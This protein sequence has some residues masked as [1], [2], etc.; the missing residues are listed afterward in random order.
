[1]CSGQSRWNDIITQ[2]L[3]KA[4]LLTVWRQPAGN[5]MEWR[6][7]GAR[8]VK[9][10]NEESGEKEQSKKDERKKRREEG[11]MSESEW[12]CG[13]GGCVFSAQ[14][15]AGLVNHRRQKH[16][17]STTAVS[18]QHC[19]GQLHP[20]GLHNRIKAM[21]TRRLRPQSALQTA[22]ILGLKSS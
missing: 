4:N 19:G 9:S 5:R 10:Q 1:M 20:Q 22:P 7:T 2:D 15:R 14:S 11:M 18:C 12:L 3:K 6:G 8:S 21:R 16:G 13:V 17:A